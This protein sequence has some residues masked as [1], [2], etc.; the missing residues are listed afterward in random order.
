MSIRNCFQDRTQR[1]SR[2]GQ[3][4]GWEEVNSGV[5]R[6]PVLGPLLFNVFRNDLEKGVNREVITFAQEKPG[7][8]VRNCRRIWHD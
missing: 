4:S 2:N 1:M 3:F 7:Q 8:T 6:G 5:P